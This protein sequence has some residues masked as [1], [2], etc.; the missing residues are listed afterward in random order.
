MCFGLFLTILEKEIRKFFL[1]LYFIIILLFSLSVRH[2][3][4]YNIYRSAR[5][6]RKIALGNFGS[7]DWC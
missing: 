3:L 2:A 5:I 1:L 6:P 7:G 4:L